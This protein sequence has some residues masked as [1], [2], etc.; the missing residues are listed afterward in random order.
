MPLG[1][2]WCER[3]LLARKQ[4]PDSHVEL[5]A[6]LG[7]LTPDPGPRQTKFQNGV[8]PFFFHRLRQE[9]DAWEDHGGEWAG[10]TG[11]QESVDYFF[12]VDPP[13]ADVDS[14]QQLIRQTVT[15]TT[16]EKGEPVQQRQF[17]KKDPLHRHNLRYTGQD[18]N[19]FETPDLRLSVNVEHRVDPSTLPLST[20]T[21]WVRIKQRRRYLHKPQGATEPIWAFDLTT[22]WEAETYTQA[23][24]LQRQDNP[25]TTVYEVEVECLHPE[26]YLND[27]QRNKVYL[28]CTFLLKLLNML[29]RTKT[30]QWIPE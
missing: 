30:F 22:V 25:D 20:K 4:Y 29:D 18:A 5:E 21:S 28:A 27:P 3:Y 16:D 17:L 2:N 9:M 24:I 10:K 19:S 14:V 7:R 1:I 6:R 8:H 15:F 23:E 26:F 11:P 12:L 13:A